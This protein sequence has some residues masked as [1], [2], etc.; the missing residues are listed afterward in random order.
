M[1]S[2]LSLIMAFAAV[3]MAAPIL[4]RDDSTIDAVNYILHLQSSP[5]GTT[6]YDDEINAVTNPTDVLG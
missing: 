6:A 1:K 3:V 2:T 4:K 5:T